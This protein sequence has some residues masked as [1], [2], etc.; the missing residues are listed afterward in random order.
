MGQYSYTGP[1]L[2][3]F[4]GNHERRVGRFSR[5][6]DEKEKNHDLGLDKDVIVCEDVWIGSNVTLLAGSTIA[7]GA[8]I[9][10]GAVVSGDIPPYS[11]SGGIPAKIIKFYWSIDEILAHEEKLY[12]VTERFT[13]EQLESIF[14][15]FNKYG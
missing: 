6:I 15:K 14:D 12:E 3:V 10:S 13:R 9:A 4:C 8:T 7:R 11:I 2:K 5:S 1:F